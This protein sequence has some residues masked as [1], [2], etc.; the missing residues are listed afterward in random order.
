MVDKKNDLSE[1]IIPSAGL[2]F[3]KFWLRMWS[4]SLL[5]QFNIPQDFLY[6]WFYSDIEL[7][8]MFEEDTL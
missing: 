7:I 3:I 5:L 2:N 8:V 1:S 4:S 6:V